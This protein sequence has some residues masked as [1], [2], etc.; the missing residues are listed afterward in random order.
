MNITELLAELA[1]TAKL[2]G[3]A[4]VGRYELFD[5]RPAS[6]PD[7]P[8]V[9]ATALQ[10]CSSCPALGA[11]QQWYRTLPPDQRPYGCVVAGQVQRR[12][13]KPPP[14]APIPPMSRM[15]QAAMAAIAEHEARIQ[16]RR[17]ST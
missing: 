4:C 17:G 7:R 15:R 6:D 3:A 5:P 11:C 14:P 8:Y 16:Q 1:M 10:I 2:P 13:P 12:V 9:E